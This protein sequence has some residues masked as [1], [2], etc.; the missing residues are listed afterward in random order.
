MAVIVC[1][2]KK[3]HHLKI[4]IFGIILKIIKMIY[5]RNAHSSLMSMVTY[6]FENECSYNNNNN[7]WL[8]SNS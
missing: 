6:Y 7:K 8:F 1:G 4:K 2:M 5:E 3:Q